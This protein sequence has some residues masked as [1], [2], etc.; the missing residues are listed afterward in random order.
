MC[1]FARDSELIVGS[2]TARSACFCFGIRF[3]PEGGEFP[4]EALSESEH[5]LL[6]V[7]AELRRLIGLVGSLFRSS[8]VINRDKLALVILPSVAVV[9]VKEEGTL[10]P[11]RAMAFAIASV[12]ILFVGCLTILSISESLIMSLSLGEKSVAKAQSEDKG[13]T[14]V[15]L[16]ISGEGVRGVRVLGRTAFDSCFDSSE[17]VNLIV[18][19]KAGESLASLISLV[20]LKSFIPLESF[21]SLIDALKSSEGEDH[22]LFKVDTAAGGDCN[23][24]LNDG[25]L[26][27][28]LRSSA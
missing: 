18:F 22:M 16:S 10:A 20:S 19:G 5:S 23:L 17:L 24:G 11:C 27:L 28:S 7:G 3:D 6:I 15:F 25:K 14:G 9:G 8:G 2:D 26:P 1:V 21:M 12:L 13:V 4:R